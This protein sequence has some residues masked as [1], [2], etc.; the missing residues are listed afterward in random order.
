MREL[1]E[2]PHAVSE[3]ALEQYLLDCPDDSLPG[4]ESLADAVRN[5][6]REAQRNQDNFEER[7]FRSPDGNGDLSQFQ[8]DNAVSKNLVAHELQPQLGS[9]KLAE[10]L[11]HLLRDHIKVLFGFPSPEPRLQNPDII[12]PEP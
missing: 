8:L 7:F 4:A 12:N 6:L 10:R 5:K 3:E 11:S 2:M 1:L 9:R